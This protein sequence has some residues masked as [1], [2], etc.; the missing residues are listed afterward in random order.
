[1]VQLPFGL[2]VIISFCC[3]TLSMMLTNFFGPI[4][5]GHSG[6]LCHALSSSSSLLLWTSACGDSQWRMAPAFFKYL[7]FLY[8]ICYQ[9]MFPKG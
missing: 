2:L 4:L 6:P 8:I 9:A 1:V 7:L 3:Y 5:W